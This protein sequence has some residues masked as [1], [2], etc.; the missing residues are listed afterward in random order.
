MANVAA[1]L[2]DRVLPAVPVRQWVLSLP[3]ELRRLAAFRADVLSALARIFHEALF[4]RYAAWAEREGLGKAPTGAVCHVQRFGSSLNLHVHFHSMALDGVYTRDDA[5]RPVFHPAPA[6]TRL[7][8]EEILRRVRRRSVA[9]LGRK[10]LLEASAMSDDAPDTT[11]LDAC[12]AV[13]VQRGTLRAIRDR[14]EGDEP[15]IAVPE[16]PRSETDAFD[17]DGFNL[18]ATV[19]IAGDDDLGRERLMRYG[20]RPPFALDRLRRL[21]DG[22][23][24]YRVSVP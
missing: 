2:V 7:E 19:V 1:H 22:R 9:W 15:C 8:L 4:A 5:D 6:P 10:G 14:P 12:A 24:A 18:H 11:A 23:I 3:F 21:P 16:P 17:L 13:A 20:A